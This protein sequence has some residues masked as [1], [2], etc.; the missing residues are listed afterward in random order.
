MILSKYLDLAIRAYDRISFSPEKRGL[1]TIIDYSSEL[2]KDLENLENQG[3]YQEKYEAYFSSWLSTKSRCLSPMITGPSNF[4]VSRNQ[5]N[6]RSEQN[7][8]EAFREWRSRYFKAANRERTLS[9][10]EEIDNALSELDKQLIAH[11]TMKGINKIIKSKSNNKE[12]KA[13]IIEEYGLS[14]ENAEKIFIPDYMGRIGFAS[15]ALANSN[16]RIKRLRDKLD[17]MRARIERKKTWEPISFDGGVIDIEADRVIIKHD[18]K[19][20][21][22]VISALKSRGFH[23]SRNYGSWSRKHTARAIY[24]AK[25]LCGV[26]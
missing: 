25:N 6:N 1:Q 11:E 12:K 21:Q 24:D 26:A 4:P 5:K 20:D 23:W 14:E 10:E 2:E 16:T 9:P 17:I 8:Y 18:E 22:S 19:P 15:Y 7:K 3:N 13:Q